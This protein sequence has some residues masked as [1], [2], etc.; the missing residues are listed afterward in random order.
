[1]KNL[2]QADALSLPFA[3]ESFDA[4]SVAFGLRN[5]ESF[6]TAFGEA[7]RVLRAGGHLLVLDFSTPRGPMRGM[8]RFYLRRI[9]PRLAG[10]VAGDRAAYEYLGASIETFPQDDALLAILAGSGF[11]EGKCE[12]LTGG[13]V[14][15]YTAK[16]SK[17]AAA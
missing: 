10:I 5:M 9:L 8:Y 6:E 4:V 1:V 16:M 12:P 3:D 7:A 17:P 13:I 11:C 2:V 14:S 15:I